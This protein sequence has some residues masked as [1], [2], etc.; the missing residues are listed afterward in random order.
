M[1]AREST[2]F[3]AESIYE[4]ASSQKRRG[5]HIMFRH[6][7]S[8]RVSLAPVFCHGDSACSSARGMLQAGAAHSI[9]ALCP[10]H[11]SREITQS[12]LVATPAMNEEALG[13]KE[14]F[15]NRKTIISRWC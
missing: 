2:Q 14:T 8:A 12:Y 7:S 4:T 13:N 11:E 9:L 15:L 10:G 6:P 3:E 1:S 5:E